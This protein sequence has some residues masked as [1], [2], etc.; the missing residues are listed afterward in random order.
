MD[1]TLR[2]R[3]FQ[4]LSARQVEILKEELRSGPPIRRADA[5]AAQSDIV[6]VA[7]RLAG[8]GRITI[9]ATEGDGVMTMPPVTSVT[10]GTAPAAT[11]HGA[12]AA[13][14]LKGDFH[15]ALAVAARG[16]VRAPVPDKK[17][18]EKSAA[19]ESDTAEKKPVVPDAPVTLVTDGKGTKGA[20]TVSGAAAEP[21]PAKEK[22]KDKP[23]PAAPVV[24]AAPEAPSS[25][26]S[27]AA[28][29]SG[30]VAVPAPAQ[31]SGPNPCSG[32][33][34]AGGG[35]RR[36]AGT[37]SGGLH[38]IRLCARR[39]GDHGALRIQRR[40]CGGQGRPGA[41]KGGGRSANRLHPGGA[42]ARGGTWTGGIL[43]GP[44]RR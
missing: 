30:E 6:E 2:N 24:A 22:D 17:T 33:G 15:A 5:L 16:E 9:S 14:D 11:K 26:A 38:R 21:V 10:H 3:F 43:P 8:E 29:A 1:D 12:K 4:N 27:A 19:K 35:A 7:L 31:D 28:K 39:Y 13:A 42:G 18:T 44:P 23:L 25:V 36:A 32:G 37:G 20:S 34:Q 41:A 40:A